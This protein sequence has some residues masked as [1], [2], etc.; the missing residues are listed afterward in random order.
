MPVLYAVTRAPNGRN[1]WGAAVY[2]IY[3]DGS[4]P[5]YWPHLPCEVLALPADARRISDEE[6]RAF[7]RRRRGNHGRS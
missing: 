6:I 5:I 3:L 7:W 4:Y 2:D 1:I